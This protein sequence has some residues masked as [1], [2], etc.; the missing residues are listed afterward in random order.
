M[1][2]LI[3]ECLYAK[4]CELMNKLQRWANFYLL[5]SAGRKARFRHADGLVVEYVE[6]EGSSPL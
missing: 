2:L 3:R 4:P 5:I 6:N 1:S